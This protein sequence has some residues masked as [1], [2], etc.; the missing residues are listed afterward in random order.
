[1]PNQDIGMEHYLFILAIQQE[2]FDPITN[3]ALSSA[4]T[5]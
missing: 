2:Q 1:M 3:I 4:V 5:Y